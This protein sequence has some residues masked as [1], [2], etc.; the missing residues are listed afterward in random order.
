[1][2]ISR[3]VP[4]VRSDSFWAT[5]SKLIKQNTFVQQLVSAAVL[6][7]EQEQKKERKANMLT[8][9]VKVLQEGGV[10]F[11]L[12]L[13]GSLAVMIH[14]LAYL[15]RNHFLSSLF[16]PYSG[17]ARYISTR[18]KYCYLETRCWA[19][20]LSLFDI[21]NFMSTVAISSMHHV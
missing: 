14:L 18:L 2:K 11:S 17:S 4:Q 1:M 6:V 5:D 19:A 9:P 16:M 21:L 7:E 13:R 8:K 10:I 3:Q 20:T 12:F 15:N